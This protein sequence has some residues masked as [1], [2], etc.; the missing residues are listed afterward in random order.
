MRTWKTRNVVHGACGTLAGAVASVLSAFPTGALAQNVPAATPADELATIVVTAQRR[1]ER[2]QDTPIAITVLGANDLAQ[3]GAADLVDVARIAPNV[4][5][6]VGPGGSGGSFNTSAYIRGVGQS[7]FLITT[8]PGV[9]VYIDGVFFPRA[10]GALLDL[11]DIERVEV[12]RG[13]QG[14]LFGRNTIGGAISVVTAKP[15]AG[16]DAYIEGTL[17]KYAR[18]ELKAYM[19]LP[20]S[21]AIQTRVSFAAKKVDGF[22]NRPLAGDRLGG[23]D[24]LVGRIH[25]VWQLSPTLALDLSADAT[26]KREDSVAQYTPTFQSA[27]NLY[28]LWKAVA[29]PVVNGNS[30]AINAFL[31]AVGNTP[32]VPNPGSPLT[33]NGTGP[34]ASNLDM[35]GVAATLIWDVSKDLQFKAITAYRGFDAA[36]GRDGDGTPIQY[37][38]TNSTVEQRQF[39]EEFQLLGKAFENRLRWVGGLYY[40]NERA[41][42]RNTVQ[43]ASGLYAGLE[44]LPAA[45]IPLAPVTCPPPPG[46]PA[47]CAGGL[48]NPINALFDLD[49][50][51]FNRTRT[52]SWAGY[53]HSTYA[54]T[55]R[56][57]LV[58]GGRYTQDDKDYF[59]VHGRVNAGVPLIPA[60]SVSR[61]DTDF[62]PKI[63]VNFKVDAGTMLYASASQGFK[64]GGFNGR[65]T[66]AAEVQSFGPEKVTSYEIGAKNEWFKRRLRLNLALFSNDYSDIQ[67]GSVQ[68][69]STGNLVLA[70]ENGGKARINGFEAEMQARP[71]EQLLID[72]SV[73]YLDAKFKS[74]APGATVTMDTKLP[75]TPHLTTTLGMAYT[76]GLAG[77]MKLLVR[78][79]ASYRS[80]AHTIIENTPE[81]AQ[82]GYS[83]LSARATLS[84]IGAPWTLTAYVTNLTDKRYIVGGIQALSSFGSTEAILGRPREAG[85]TFGYAFR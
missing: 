67:L 79:D 31:A 20:G 47:P 39:S 70:I 10:T 60:T 44:S 51:V 30:A 34:N 78:G 75:R 36:F 14:T 15:G 55:E 23:I 46:V 65:P 33:S 80:K 53:I 63:G 61:K 29:K 40:F 27:G 73:G 32:V 11:V 37:L 85:I 72:L 16:G 3:R 77:N 48:G 38:H 7:D 8:D 17:G 66:T 41:T 35:S 13:P 6:S 43:L 56:L 82:S 49:F 26:R 81:L 83:L 68:A 59:L 1:Q 4:D 21:D 28:P 12:L 58:L 64:S 5:I 62:S 84:Q 57:D 19:D 9:G 74:I 50:D 42:D 22:V 45:V 76:L 25:T 69:D 18:R 24:S 71:Y 2:L 52:S 54:A